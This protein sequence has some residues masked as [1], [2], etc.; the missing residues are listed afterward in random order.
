MKRT[1]GKVALVSGAARG[2]GRSHAVHLAEEGADIIAF[3][4]CADISTN[5][6]ELATEEDLAHTVKLV[7]AEG[8]R[9]V[10]AK[11]D[12]RDRVGLEQ[13][14]AS[15]VEKLSR[16]DIVVANAGICPLGADLPV[17]A[18]IDAFDVDFVGVV[19][20]I[21]AAIPHLGDGG[22]IIATGSLAAL[23]PAGLS[24]PG[25]MGYGLA[26]R[27]IPNYIRSVAHLLAAKG[28]RA[29]TIHPTNCNTDM[30]HSTPM[31]RMFRDDLD[32]PTLADV[33]DGFTSMQAIPTPWV[34]PSD[35]SSAVV[36]LA[37][38]ESRYLTGQEIR[39][40]AGAGLNLGL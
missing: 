15:A 33:K 6:Y 3:D 11:V 5:E 12:V 28:I 23:M 17:Q 40:D 30:L 2:Q 26:K 1:Q 38:D 39:I 36:Y 24:S 31:Y 9:I 32:N 16:L 8:R 14:L 22:S 29:N 25:G 18:F 35:I 37:S 7:E 19:N 13:E 4:L 10:A 34:E 20:T 27:M 21:H